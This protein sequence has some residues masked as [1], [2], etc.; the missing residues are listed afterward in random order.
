MSKKIEH[1]AERAER[2]AEQG[3]LVLLGDATTEEALLKGGITR[4][5]GLICCLASDADNVFTVL[6]GRELNPNLDIVSRAINDKAD[7]KLRKAGADKTVSPNEIGGARMASLVPP[8]GR[9]LSG[10]A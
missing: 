7:I 2:L 5:K 8:G 10:C 9:E 4:A 1:N 3:N 6:T